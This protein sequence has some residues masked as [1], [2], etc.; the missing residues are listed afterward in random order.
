MPVR[1]KEKT[2]TGGQAQ[3]KNIDDFLY[4]ASITLSTGCAKHPSKAQVYPP[5]VPPHTLKVTAKRTF[6]GLCL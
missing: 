6:F 3:K 4:E 1:E 5:K 2:S